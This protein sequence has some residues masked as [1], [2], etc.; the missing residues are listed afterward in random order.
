MGGVLRFPARRTA[1]HPH[2]IPVQCLCLRLGHASM[3]QEAL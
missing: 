3:R 1:T 2:G